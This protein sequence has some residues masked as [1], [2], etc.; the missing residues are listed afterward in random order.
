MKILEKGKESAKCAKKCVKKLPIPSIP[1][2]KI[3]QAK[4]N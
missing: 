3:K 1:E 2:K 4:N